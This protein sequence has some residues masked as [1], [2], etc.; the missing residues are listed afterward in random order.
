MK[1]KEH[2]KPKNSTE[3]G[4]GPNMSQ[5]ENQSEGQDK[6]KKPRETVR[7]VLMNNLAGTIIV[8]AVLFGLYNILGSSADAPANVSISEL[9]TNINAGT[10]KSIAVT[11]DVLD[12]T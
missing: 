3:Q 2:K 11:G 10:V 4:T 9:V 7:G 5:G 1:N 6:S 8:F 12:I